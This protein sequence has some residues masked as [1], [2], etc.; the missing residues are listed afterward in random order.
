MLIFLNFLTEGATSTES[1]A[2]SSTLSESTTGS[3]SSTEL[4][5]EGNQ[6]CLPYYYPDWAYSTDKYWRA[7]FR[8]EWTCSTRVILS[9]HQNP[10]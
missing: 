5:T 1:P 9:P 10:T 7:M 8:Y 2:E 6:R 4:G 3:E